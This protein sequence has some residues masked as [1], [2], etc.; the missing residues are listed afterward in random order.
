MKLNLKGF[1][2]TSEYNANKIIKEKFIV[3]TKRNNEW[4]G[5]GIYF[6]KYKV[7]AQSWGEQ[8]Y[9][10]KPIPAIIECEL[11]VEED[12]FLDL[13]NPE[14]KNCFETYFEE[15]LSELTLNNISLDF[16]DRNQAI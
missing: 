14:K 9:Y 11:E 6:F 8:T 13:D 3:N 5:H 2:A 4:L 16:K 15:V 1:H 10:C 12:R 7:D